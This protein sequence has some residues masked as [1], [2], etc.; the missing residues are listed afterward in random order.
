MSDITSSAAQLIGRLAD[1]D[2]VAREKQAVAEVAASDAML[3]EVRAQRDDLV[4]EAARQRELLARGLTSQSIHDAA[5]T[6]ATVVG[7]PHRVGERPARDLR[8]PA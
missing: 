7:G 1:E 8:A 5:Q 6:A 2:L 3:G 4:R